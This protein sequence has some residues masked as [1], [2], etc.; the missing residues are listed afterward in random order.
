VVGASE[1]S[2]TI[3]YFTPSNISGDG[4]PLEYSLNTFAVS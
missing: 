4:L 1:T 2:I 3:Q